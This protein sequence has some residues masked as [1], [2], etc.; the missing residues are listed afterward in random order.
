MDGWFGSDYQQGPAVVVPR[1]APKLNTLDD[2]SA[3]LAKPLDGSPGLERTGLIFGASISEGWQAAVRDSF[4]PLQAW[5]LRCRTNGTERSASPH[6]RRLAV[7]SSHLRR[8]FDGLHLHDTT[9]GESPNP[10]VESM[11]IV[12]GALA[13]FIEGQRVPVSL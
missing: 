4:A 2:V 10:Y 12:G 1:N 9:L 8:S 7:S 13:P 11:R 5:T 6:R 3:N